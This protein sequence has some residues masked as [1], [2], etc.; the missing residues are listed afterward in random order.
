[1]C[2]GSRKTTCCIETCKKFDY[3]HENIW[4]ENVKTMCFFLQSLIGRDRL[5]PGISIKQNISLMKL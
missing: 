1:M 2:K 3:F 5:S 4:L